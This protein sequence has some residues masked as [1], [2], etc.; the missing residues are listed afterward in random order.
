MLLCVSSKSLWK[1]KPL[2]LLFCVSTTASHG[3]RPGS[4]R[5]EEQPNVH[6]ERAVVLQYDLV[7]HWL[8]VAEFPLGVHP[9][10]Y[11][12]VRGEGEWVLPELCS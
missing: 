4:L 10:L 8:A 11:T 5:G 3:Y 12:V 2:V 7:R 1:A 9:D 6:C